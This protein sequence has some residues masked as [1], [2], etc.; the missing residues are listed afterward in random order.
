MQKVINK[1]ILLV[2]D[3]C[4]DKFVYCK[5]D[6]LCPEA[7]IPLLDI[8]KTKTNKGMAGN[9][10]KNLNALGCE[11][12]FITN[13]NYKSIIKTRYVDEKTNHMF[14][15]IDTK[16]DPKTRYKDY[17]SEI[18]LGNYSAVV[19]S[20]YN[21]GFITEKEIEFISYNHPL[22]FLDTKKIIGEWARNIKFIKINRAE[23][24]LSKRYLSNI[25]KENIIT[26]LGSG[27]AIYRDIQYDVEDVEVKDLSGAGDTFLSGLVCKFLRTSDVEESIKFA[28]KCASEVVQKK[29]VNIIQ[30]NFIT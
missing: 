23:Y 30:K 28:N 5:C 7:P 10:E 2:G 1:P 16:S 17:S 4:I 3:S 21:K 14:I 25:I 19:I 12:E 6:R 15:R 9:V 22:T 29:G 24:N 13:K 27:G 26:T 8:V 11:V 20:D 18:N